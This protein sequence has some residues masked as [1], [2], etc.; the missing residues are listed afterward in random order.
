[1]PI[2][3][4]FGGKKE[5]RPP[6]KRHLFKVKLNCGSCCSAVKKA[7]EGKGGVQAVEC[8]VDK[9]EVVIEGWLSQE[10]ASGYLSKAGKEHSFISTL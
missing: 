4:I 1:M 8:S 9:Q 7:V 3:G 2:F 10:E 6:M 5:D